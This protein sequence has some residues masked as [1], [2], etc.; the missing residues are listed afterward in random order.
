[1]WLFRLLLGLYPSGFRA[2]YG[3]AMTMDAEQAWRDTTKLLCLI[4]FLRDFLLGWPPVV[5]QELS[6]DLRYALRNWHSSKSSTLIAVLSLSIAIGVSTAVFSMVNAMLFARLPF[7]NVE[8]LVLLKNHFAPV[9]KG[10]QAVTQ[11]NRQSHYLSNST[12]FSTAN[13]YLPQSRGSRQIKG[14]ETSANF[15]NVLGAPLMLGRSFTGEEE[16]PGKSDVV[17]LSH[18]LF[19]EAFGGDRRILGQTITIQNKKLTVVGIAPPTF[20]YPD[21]AAFWTPKIFDWDSMPKS[22]VSFQTTVGRLKPSLTIAQAQS[23]FRAESSATIYGKAKEV[24][25]RPRLIALREVIA[26]DVY[27]SSIA[28]F[29]AVIAMVAIA[30]V[31]L[32]ALL[33]SRYAQRAAEFRTRLFLG[34]QLP[35]LRQQV[36]TECALIGAASGSLGLFIALLTTR[37]L[38]IYRE[39]GFAFQTY[40]L[41]D[42]HV[43]SFALLLAL[44]CGFV[45]GIVACFSIGKPNQSWNSFWRQGLLISQVTLTVLLLGSSL[46][47]SEAM[48]KLQNSDLGFD[49]KQVW[50]ASITLAGSSID[51]EAQRLAYFE[52]SL[53]RVGALEGIESVSA[54]NYLPL[55]SR[56]FS[57]RRFNVPSQTEPLMALK[58]QISPNYFKTLQTPILAGRDFS[59]NDRLGTPFV[60]IVNDI[61]ARRYGGVEAVIGKKLK[62]FPDDNDD[63]IVIGVVKSMQY[64]G[65]DSEAGPMFY[66]PMSQFPPRYFTVAARVGNRIAQPA[67]M[68]RQTLQSQDT[69]I[70]IYDVKPMQSRV[71]DHLMYPV[72]LASTMTFFGLFS[73]GLTLLHL[74]GAITLQIEERRRELG[75]RMAI[76]ATVNQL[77]RFMSGKILWPITLGLALGAILREPA[78]NLLQSWIDLKAITTTSLDQLA[79]VSMAVVILITLGLA[80]SGIARLD[81]MKNLRSE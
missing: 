31:N 47:L 54:V 56:S 44:T 59:T 41:L 50:T 35:R 67:A 16:T 39:P 77:R 20:N 32:A 13:F 27:K 40:T 28:L 71:D 12:S 42:W 43:L 80:T 78:R 58:I 23:A 15:F 63:P 53:D 6:Q 34:A 25:M 11:W 62:G 64:S 49:A 29:F 76:G 14:A 19:E 45:C 51:T 57:G 2:E 69:Q 70:P 38:T 10:A 75:I 72:F 52:S 48:L 66:T 24:E 21:S 73:V 55:A 1:M 65:P 33:L 30:C 5:Y 4:H 22:G 18:A 68:L 61:F 46:T 81:P 17:V 7:Q 60:A 37:W 9:Y 74:F 79:A 36:L 8:E 3:A 26:G